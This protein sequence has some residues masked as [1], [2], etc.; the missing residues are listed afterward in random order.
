MPGITPTRASS[1][2]SGSARSGSYN[3]VLLDEFAHIQQNLANDFYTS[4][5]PVITSG[6]TTKIFMI[7]TPK[8]MNLFYNFWMDAVG[9]RNDYIPFEIHWRDVPGRD[10]KWYQETLKN[11]GEHRFK[12]EFECEFLGSADTLIS[13]PG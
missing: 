11:I 4:V 5:Y 9:K 13:G 7:S 3:I 2:T 8:G 12:Q 6:T 10:E 1:T